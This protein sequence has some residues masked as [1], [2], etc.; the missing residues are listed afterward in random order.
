MT[1]NALKNPFE[2]GRELST[3]ELVDRRDELRTVLRSM[4]NRAKLFLIGPRR[5]GKTS[6][7]KVASS[8]AEER[9]IVVLRYDAEAYENLELLAEALLTGAARSLAGPLDKVKDALARVAGH[10]KPEATYDVNDARLSVSIGAKAPGKGAKR[11]D[12]PIL[13]DVLDAVEALAKESGKVVVVIIDEFQQ[14]VEEKGI[15]AEKQ[16]RARVQR[17]EHVGYIFAGSATRLLADMTGDPGRA[18]YK[19]GGR[20]FLG[21]I[22]RE[23]F[24]EFL[25]AG[26]TNSGF[27][28]EAEA[29]NVILDLAEEV[30][31]NV[32]QLAHQCWEWLREDSIRVLTES[33]VIEGRDRIVQQEN[34]VY[35]QIWKSLTKVQKVTLKAVI[36]ENGRNLTSEETTRK[37]RI[38]ASSMDQALSILDKRA[39]VREEALVGDVCYRLE[40]PFFGAWLQ[41]V[42]AQ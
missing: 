27:R 7:L 10:L 2:F 42:Q 16:I 25:R 17:H 24:A 35:T 11:D 32:Q 41:M 37:Y 12:L 4:E 22:P 34:P 1:T 29:P 33:A 19:L 9:D 8:K 18:F 26:F 30:P 20:L 14:V 39:L 13:A 38:G 23:E 5:Y 28:I 15:T 36:Q 3:A 6:L 40:D 21:S 31:Y